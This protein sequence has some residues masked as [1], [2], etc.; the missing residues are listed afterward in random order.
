MRLIATIAVAICAFVAHATHLAPWKP[1]V[2]DESLVVVADGSR[3]IQRVSSFGTTSFAY[4]AL[5]RLVAR[6]ADGIDDH[7]TWSATGELL[8]A[9]NAV[10][11]ETF[12]YDVCGRLA[13]AVTGIGTNEYATAWLRDAG[14]LVTNISYGAGFAVS[15]E[16]DADG[17]LVAVRDSFGHEW[18]FL[19]D[20]EGRPLGG[21][22][23][24]GWA[25]AFSYDAAGQLSGWSVGEIAGRSIMRDAAGRRVRD[26]VTAGE[27]PVPQ[28]TRRAQ[29]VFDGAGR[30]V[31][32]T[33]EYGTN[34]PVAEVYLHDASGAM[35]N[36][37]SGGETVFLAQYDALGRLVSLGGPSS[38]AAAYDALGNR[39]CAGGR[40][41]IPDHDDSLKRPLL[42][43]DEDGT[44]V[45]A[46]IWGAGQLLG[47]LDMVGRDDPIAP[48]S[49]T[50]AHCDEQGSVIALTTADGTLLHTAHYGPHGEDWGSSGENPTPFAWLGGWGVMR[51]LTTYNSQL[52]T[53]N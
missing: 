45:R 28:M 39:V 14:G 9:S 47:W 51:Q 23:P 34:A 17:R 18:T 11:A 15:R 2:G 30:I 3:L 27:M 5:D 20:G 36:V 40:I 16:Y 42:E 6:T 43:C 49:L 46:Y 50:V 10:A 1:G 32:A 26:T 7:L 8:A 13:S 37:T 12:S 52:A 48:P 44:P 33:V 24:D 22:S 38:S 31:S 53:H 19:W 29:N 35:T 41:W 25:H 4:D 21:L